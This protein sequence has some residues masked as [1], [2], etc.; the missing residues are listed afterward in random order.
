MFNWIDYAILGIILIS[1]YIG[2]KKGFIFAV[3]KIASFFISVIA[4]MY[5]YPIVSQFLVNSCHIDSKLKAWIIPNLVEK[6]KNQPAITTLSPAGQHINISFPQ[7]PIAGM[8]LPRNLQDMITKNIQTGINNTQTTILDGVANGLTT[9]AV[10]I[11]SVMALY[12]AIRIVLTL[13]QFLLQGV[14]ELPLFKQLNKV[15]GGTLGMLE[16]VLSIYVIFAILTFF[17][18]T[19]EMQNFIKIMQAST[20][21]KYFYQNNLILL[22]IF[23]K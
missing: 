21:A 17:S 18:A 9:I 10:N 3:F 11:I 12:F 2:Y 7:G 5:F 6:F 13:L 8:Q 4:S 23:G 15:G 20:L 14:A 19:G 1:G 22:W 16:G